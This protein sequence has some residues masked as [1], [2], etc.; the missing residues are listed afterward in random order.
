MLIRQVGDL[1]RLISRVAVGK[2][3][4]REVLQIQRALDAIEPIRTLCLESSCTPMLKAGDQ[5]NPCLLI[6]QRI[7]NELMPEPSAL[8]AKGNVIAKGVSAELDELRMIA[9]SGKDYLSGLRQ[10]EMERTGIPNIKI[11]FN[12]VFGYYIE[13]TNTHKDKIPENWERKQ[14]LVNVS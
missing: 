4:P 5:L 13:V 10:R 8:I 1:E 11:S 12:N 2:V 7:A 3:N 6:K 14:T 9:H